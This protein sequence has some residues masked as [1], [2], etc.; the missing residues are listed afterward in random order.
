M[1][2]QVEVRR[3]S[4]GVQLSGD[5][6]GG[7]KVVEPESTLSKPELDRTL[8]FK[9]PGYNRTRADFYSHHTLHLRWRVLIA[10]CP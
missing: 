5:L 8:D 10:G 6:H 1:R 4:H 9:S 2:V 3:A 7:P